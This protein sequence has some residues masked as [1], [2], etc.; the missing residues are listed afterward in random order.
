M[1]VK[2]ILRVLIILTILIAGCTNCEKLSLNQNEKDWVNHFQK[3]QRTYFKNI[4]SQIDTVEVTETRNF[5]TPCNKFELSKYQ[6]EVYDVSFIIKSVSNY[7]NDEFLLSY[8]TTDYKPRVPN[9]F[10][11]NLG[12]YRNDL[13]NKMPLAIDTVLAGK[14]LT[15]VYY[16]IKDLNTEN[17]GEKEYFKNFFW[18]KRSGLIAYT[19]VNDELFL[20]FNQ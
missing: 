16:Y 9:I 12:P 20:R 3:G 5:Y 1:K 14:K 4:K 17:Y 15:S 13:E 11:G 18:D 6:Y 19:T 2:C 8:E 7:N 10:F